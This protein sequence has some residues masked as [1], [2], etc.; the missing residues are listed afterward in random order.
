MHDG[1]QN[2]ESFSDTESRECRGKLTGD[3]GS[4]L[5]GWPVSWEDPVIGNRR[6]PITWDTGEMPGTVLGAGRDMPAVV[7]QCK[8]GSVGWRG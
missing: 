7:G 5:L 3:P 2:K 1:W 4:R 8:W 6:D